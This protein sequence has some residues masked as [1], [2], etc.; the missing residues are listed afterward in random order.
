[1]SVLA[2]ID[3]FEG[4]L[5]QGRPVPLT[6]E[7]RVERDGLEAAV[8]RLRSAAAREDV[9]AEIERLA[10]RAKKVPLTGQVRLDPE[11]IRDLLGTLRGGG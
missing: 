3:E 6:P 2:A 9:V 5:A 11:P 8:A 4:L 7:V 1:V 10:R